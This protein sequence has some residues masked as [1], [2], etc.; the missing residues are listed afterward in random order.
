[1]AF[2]DKFYQLF[3]NLGPKLPG[4]ISALILGYIFIR[5]LMAI[6]RRVLRISK[7]HK[8][9]IEII[10]SLAN[11]LLWILLLS[12]IARQLGLASLALT[13]SGS[14][15]ALGFAMANGLSSLTA[16]IISGVFLSKDQDFEVGYRI[17]SGDIEGVVEKI[18]MRKIRIRDDAGKLFVL[19]SSKVDSLGWVVLEKK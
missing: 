1:M 18:D 10:T 6:I 2:L 12:E 3:L 11:I 5:I 19:P 8:A 17:K 14:V 4:V 15:I 13:I 7:T 16:D 9:L